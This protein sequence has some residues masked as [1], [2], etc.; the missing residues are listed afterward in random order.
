MPKRSLIRGLV[1]G[2]G[3][4][5]LVFFNSNS[6]A[7]DKPVQKINDEVLY[8]SLIQKVDEGIKLIE[9]VLIK[10]KPSTSTPEYTFT[11]EDAY[12]LLQ[13][14]I[15]EGVEFVEPRLVGRDSTRTITN[16]LTDEYVYEMLANDKVESSET[17]KTLNIAPYKLTGGILSLNDED[18]SQLLKDE[19]ANGKA[20]REKYPQVK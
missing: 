1:A 11:D 16:A 17:T 15:R 12:R 14:E 13:D 6:Y 3:L 19:E 20:L 9:P 7:E 8:E 4:A 2:L 5:G 10:D 18:T